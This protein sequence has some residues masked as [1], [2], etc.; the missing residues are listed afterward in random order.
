M[1]ANTRGVSCA[2]RWKTC[3]NCCNDYFEGLEVGARIE[4]AVGREREAPAH[5]RHAAGDVQPRQ[6]VARDPGRQQRGCVERMQG[7]HE[8]PDDKA[9]GARAH[10]PRGIVPARAERL[11]RGVR[12][13]TG[14]LGFLGSVFGRSRGC[15]F[16]ADPALRA[17]SLTQKPDRP[18][19][20]R[21]RR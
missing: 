4:A 14:S 3:E 17:E 10:E 6:A 20:E 2:F 11:E 21:L 5:R 1:A 13:L 12:E 16:V 18:Y 19:Q 8:E 7:A 15:A 9:L